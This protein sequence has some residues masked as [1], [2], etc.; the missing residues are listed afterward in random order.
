MRDHSS[1]PRAVGAPPWQSLKAWQVSTALHEAVTR[2]SRRWPLDQQDLLGSDLRN[3]ASRTAGCIMLSSGRKASKRKVLR[4]LDEACGKLARVEC[5]IIMAGDFKL[6]AADRRRATQR[7]ARR[8]FRLTSTL[9][10]RAEQGV[11]K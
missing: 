5:L 10:A 8:A 4:W 11:R 9:R 1:S 2:A 6:L 3:S 7:L